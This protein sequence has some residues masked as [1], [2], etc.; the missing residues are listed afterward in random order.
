MDRNGTKEIRLLF[1]RN[2]SRAIHHCSGKT[3]PVAT[4]TDFLS[5]GHQPVSENM[6]DEFH[7]RPEINCTKFDILL[8]R[9]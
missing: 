7:V 1:R 2:R 3:D 8:S 9:R 5:V 4:L 6:L